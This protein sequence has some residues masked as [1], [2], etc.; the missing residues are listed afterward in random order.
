[1]AL[2]IA[3]TCIDVL[4]LIAVFALYHGRYDAPR[5]PT[6]LGSFMPW[7]SGSHDMLRDLGETDGVRAEGGGL[8]LSVKDR[9]FCLR[10]G[11]GVDGGGKRVWVLD[12]VKREAE[13]VELDL[14]AQSA[15]PDRTG[16]NIG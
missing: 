4:A 8:G 14:V 13:E 10:S 3:I 2:I 9:E 6:T 11:G 1:M 16:G 7:V 12:Y 5:I 15:P